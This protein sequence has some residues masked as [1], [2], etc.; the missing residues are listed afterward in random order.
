MGNI[1]KS[2]LIRSHNSYPVLTME[3]DWSIWFYVWDK[4]FRKLYFW[5]RYEVYYESSVIQVVM[6]PTVWLILTDYY[7]A[8]ISKI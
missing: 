1:I 4:L 6:T 3:F 2:D 5:L 7:H 8:M